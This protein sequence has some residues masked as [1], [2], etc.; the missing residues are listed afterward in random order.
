MFNQQIN[1]HANQQ[2]NL[3]QTP[4]QQANQVASNAGASRGSSW[5]I[6][7]SVRQINGKSIVTVR[8]S[9]PRKSLFRKDK[10]SKLHKFSIKFPIGSMNNQSPLAMHFNT[11][12]RLNEN[13]FKIAL[14]PQNA[15]K[16]LPVAVQNTPAPPAATTPTTVTSTIPKTPSPSTNDVNTTTTNCRLV[17]CAHIKSIMFNIFFFVSSLFRQTNRIHRM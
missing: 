13:N 14:R 4:V 5:H 9:L 6:P 3:Q 2:Q 8:K 1:F 11:N 7:E 16:P 17:I 12:G 15:Q 10:S